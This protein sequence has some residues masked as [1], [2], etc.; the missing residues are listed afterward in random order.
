MY[1]I[2]LASPYKNRLIILVILLFIS[3]WRHNIT[4]FISLL[5]ERRVMGASKKM[6]S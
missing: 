1:S 4:Q 2:I 3:T 5:S 6:P